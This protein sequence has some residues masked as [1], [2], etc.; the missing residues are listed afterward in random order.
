[1]FVFLHGEES[2]ILIAFHAVIILYILYLFNN[3]ESIKSI[4]NIILIITG[5]IQP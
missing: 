5:P 4:I 1:M 2:S 3:Q